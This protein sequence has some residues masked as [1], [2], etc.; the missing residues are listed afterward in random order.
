MKMCRYWFKITLLTILLASGFW[1]LTSPAHAQTQDWG[2]I[3]SHCVGGAQ[4]DVATIRGLEC[5]V[6]NVL[7]VAVTII[8]LGGFVMMIYGSFKYL[9]SGGNAKGIETARSTITFAIV[10]LAV[11]LSAYFILNILAE[12]T[13][14]SMITRF[15]IPEINQ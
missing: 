9:L 13:G 2:T 4:G 3:N 15:Q 14:I 8:G 6:A 11:A 1:L 7:T 5:L 10:G 12:F